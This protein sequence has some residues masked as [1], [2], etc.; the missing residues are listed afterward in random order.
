MQIS[1]KI[2]NYD[3]GV[4]DAEKTI[5]ELTESTL[6]HIPTLTPPIIPDTSSISTGLG[7]PQVLSAA[8]VPSPVTNDSTPKVATNNNLRNMRSNSLP[9]NWL[10][11]GQDQGQ[12]LLRPSYQTHFQ[13]QR[14]YQA[15]QSTL[16]KN[17]NNNNN[18]NNNNNTNNNNNINCGPTMQQRQNGG[19]YSYSSNQDFVNYN[20]N[21]ANFRHQN[22]SQQYQ[23][24]SSNQHY[25]NNNQF[26]EHHGNSG[27]YNNQDAFQSSHRCQQRTACTENDAVGQGNNIAASYNNYYNGGC[28]NL[29]C[30]QQCSQ[31][32]SNYYNGYQNN[33]FNGNYPRPNNV[34]HRHNQMH[35][36][37]QQQQYYIDLDRKQENQAAAGMI[38]ENTS[39][40]PL[41]PMATD[42]LNE[43]N[44]I[45]F[46]DMSTSLNA[47]D[48]ENT[49]FRNNPNNY[50]TS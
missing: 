39:F 35:Q 44:N 10:G 2:D 19:R 18:V 6:E 25:Q 26:H 27:Y 5:N 50:S 49:Y 7:S 12:D 38:N 3:L 1:E 40:Q 16:F 15:N 29:Q 30:N 20:H 14:I 22:N 48:I 31:Q 45:V 41:P 8:P 42:E 17:N 34:N 21:Y 28:N 36:Q 47:W 23:M 37:Q 4:F 13:N 43:E 9:V 46:K 33:K 24:K 32:H 11:Q